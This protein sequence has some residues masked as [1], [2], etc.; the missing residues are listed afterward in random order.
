MHKKAPQPV[1]PPASPSWKVSVASC[2]RQG[3]LGVGSAPAELAEVSGVRAG[4]LSQEGRRKIP[5][6]LSRRN[7]KGLVCS[8]Y[9]QHLPEGEPCADLQKGRTRGPELELLPCPTTEP[10]ST[11]PTLDLSPPYL[12]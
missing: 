10:I 8:R 4:L 9:Q 11:S 12:K 7:T 3:Q 2:T 1:S 5:W 6:V